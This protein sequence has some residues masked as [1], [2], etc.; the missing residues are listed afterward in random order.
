MGVPVDLA[1]DGAGVAA[2]NGGAGAAVDA[3]FA[4]AG[5]WVAAALSFL[6]ERVAMYGTPIEAP[7]IVAMMSGLDAMCRLGFLAWLRSVAARLSAVNSVR[8]E[9]LTYGNGIRRNL[10][11]PREIGRFASP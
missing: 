7:S 2:S 11:R 5:T 6:L 4:A 9:C 1:A 10:H 8:Q 3:V